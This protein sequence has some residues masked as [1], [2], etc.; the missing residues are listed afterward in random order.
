VT[1]PAGS[2]R[3]L[4][5]LRG[6]LERFYYI[7][8]C[9][10]CDEAVEPPT[11]S[12]FVCKNCLS[13]LPFRMGKE[14]VSWEGSF[15]LYATFFYKDVL[16][17]LIVSMKFSE[18][19]DRARAL[20]PLMARTIQRQGLTADAIIPVPLHR[21][22]LAER[23][24]NQAVILADF[25]SKSTGIPVLNSLLLR[26]L[27][28]DRQSEARSVR[29]RKL[30]MRDAFCLD[31]T[32]P[33]VAGLA[34]RPVLLLDDVVTTGSTLMEAARPLLAEGLRVTGLVAATG[35]DR[36]LGYGEAAQQW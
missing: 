36:Y 22:R 21:R 19:T 7:P 26:H 30:H 14:E 15:P 9:A 31:R 4:S 35:R 8:Y 2:H 32:S 1:E 24:Y 11:P 13:Q 6:A 12:P 16:P 5:M 29:E 18:R 20:A 10:V 17:G 23:G 34:G 25:L 28:T 33:L 3:F 27:E